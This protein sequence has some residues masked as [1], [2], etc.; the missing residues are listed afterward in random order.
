MPKVVEGAVE[1]IGDDGSR[2]I[3]LSALD[4]IGLVVYTRT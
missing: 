1:M 4:R 3:V 2:R